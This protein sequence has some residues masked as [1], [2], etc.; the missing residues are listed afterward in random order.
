MLYD[1]EDG[2]APG[3]YAVNDGTGTQYRT[4]VGRG[5]EGHR[6]R[7]SRRSGG[8]TAV[9]QA[10]D[11]LARGPRHFRTRSHTFECPGTVLKVSAEAFVGR[12]CTR[13]DRHRPADLGQVGVADVASV[14]NGHTIS[15]RNSFGDGACPGPTKYTS[16]GGPEG[17]RPLACIH[18]MTA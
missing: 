13:R 6:S 1:F 8:M 15:V 16:R 9:R 2:L 18:P 14:A 7:R 12:A 10:A 5:V 17:S 3:W 4:G 11:A